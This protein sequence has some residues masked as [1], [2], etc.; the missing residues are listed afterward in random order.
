MHHHCL[1]QVEF[2]KLHRNYILFGK[3]TFLGVQ[4][5]LE[6]LGYDGPQDAEGLHSVNWGVTQGDGGKWGWVPLVVYNHLH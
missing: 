5:P 4:L 2:L 3:G 6:V 1:W